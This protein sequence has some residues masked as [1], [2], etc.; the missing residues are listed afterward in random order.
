[1]SMN[2][3]VLSRWSGPAAAATKNPNRI[4]VRV[5]TSASEPF[6]S[7][8]ARGRTIKVVVEP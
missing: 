7:L 2:G 5:A 3:T 1:M 8:L 6:R 4:F